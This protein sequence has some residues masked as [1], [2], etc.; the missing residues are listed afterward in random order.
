MINSVETDYDKGFNDKFQKN[1][2]SFADKYLK[3]ERLKMSEFVTLN[4]QK[5]I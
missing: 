1:P 4:T 5:P 2:I 3:K